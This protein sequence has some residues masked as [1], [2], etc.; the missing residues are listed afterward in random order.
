MTSAC[1]LYRYGAYRRRSNHEP[2][3]QINWYCSSWLDGFQKTW[4]GF[5]KKMTT[6]KCTSGLVGIAYLPHGT[7]TLDP[8]RADLPKTAE[9][10]HSS[11]LK[12]GE[13]IVS[14]DPELL[15][16]LTP[17]G[18][19]LHHAFNIYQPGVSDGRASGTAEWNQ[20]WRNYSVDVELDGAASR[21]LHSY[22]KQRLPNVEGMLAFGGLSAPLRW[23]EVVPL[24]FALH[25]WTTK[26]SS[27]CRPPKAIIIA[28]PARGITG[29]RIF[30][31][32]CSCF[33]TEYF[34]RGRERR[35]S[36]ETTYCST[37]IRPC[38]SFVVWS[39]IE[40]DSSGD[41]WWSS[42]YACVVFGFTVD[43]PA[44]SLL[45]VDLSTSGHFLRSTV[46]CTDL[47]VDERRA[48]HR[49]VSV[50]SASVSR[51]S[52][53]DREI[54]SQLWLRWIIDSS[55]RLRQRMDWESNGSIDTV[56]RSVGL[57]GVDR[58]FYSL[59]NILR[60]ARCIFRSIR[61]T[62]KCTAWQ[63]WPSASRKSSC[64]FWL[65]SNESQLHSS[66]HA[67]RV[68]GLEKERF[69][70]SL[71]WLLHKTLIIMFGLVSSEQSRLSTWTELML[72]CWSSRIA[73]IKVWIDASH[74]SY[75]LSILHLQQWAGRPS[76][77]VSSFFLS[78]ESVDANSQRTFW[79]RT[80][81]PL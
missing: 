5:Q 15:I 19:N 35:L 37:R 65:D 45:S 69:T 39:I 40:A 27:V 79:I 8:S 17:H 38:T 78:F 49:L 68:S 16:L 23:G 24:Y 21:D 44:W 75:V 20:E 48:K 34:F 33:A 50:R 46:R 18:I 13:K 2:S 4:K 81:V 73:N 64:Y 53:K 22:L 1:I 63:C 12:I 47:S 60:Y 71:G 74:F 41:Q 72:F 57:L 56:D 29:M 43:L 59:S 31:E 77:K 36:C 76:L 52:G 67:D 61:S 28:Q 58:L 30:D 7:M 6:A 80:Q 42:S 26:D 51:R 10:L 9:L 62:I 11:C 3:K 54:C 14:L 55:R 32:S 66:G 70:D 25:P